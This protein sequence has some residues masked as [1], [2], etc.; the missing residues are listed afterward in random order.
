[1]ICGAGMKLKLPSCASW[2]KT[3]N[4][5]TMPQQ[6][7]Y[8]T[9]RSLWLTSVCSACSSNL[10]LVFTDISC[11]AHSNDVKT[12]CHNW[13]ISGWSNIT[14]PGVPV[15][16]GALPKLPLARSWIESRPEWGSVENWQLQLI[17]T[18]DNGWSDWHTDDDRFPNKPSRGVFCVWRSTW[19]L[20]FWASF[21]SNASFSQ[22]TDEHLSRF[23]PRGKIFFLKRGKEEADSMPRAACILELRFANMLLHNDCLTRPA[24]RWESPTPFPPGALSET[25][26]SRLLRGWVH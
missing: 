24:S 18:G 13:M 16:L 26:H 11:A 21:G 4:A 7:P 23:F 12:I 8:A 9:R 5:A 19:A 15:T 2:H 14:V 25:L 1:M 3:L 22:F 17:V 10:A 20:N 6:T